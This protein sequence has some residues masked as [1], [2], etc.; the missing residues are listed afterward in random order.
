MRPL[1]LEL[2]KTLPS[3]LAVIPPPT[4]WD[5]QGAG[6]G[7]R[8]PGPWAYLGCLD[9]FSGQN[10]PMEKSKKG[11]GWAEPP[12]GKVPMVPRA[13]EAKSLQRTEWGR[14]SF[15]WVVCSPK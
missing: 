10:L 13:K 8:G 15:F 1:L 14:K 3:S 2:L 9:S 5:L 6:E 4:C 11:G 7:S 12:V